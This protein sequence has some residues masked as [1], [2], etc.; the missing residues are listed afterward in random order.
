MNGLLRVIILMVIS[1]LS[2]VVFSIA[3]EGQKSLERTADPI[4]VSGRYLGNLFGVSLENMGLFA[5]A[6]GRFLPIPYQVDEHDAK[7]NLIFSNGK[8][9]GRDNDPAFDIND[10]LVFMV[11]DCGDRVSP[12]NFSEEV[13]KAVELT[14]TDPVNGQKG[15]VYAVAYKDSPKRSPVD[16]VR[17][18]NS[19]NVIYARNY[20]MGFSKSAPIAIGHLA[21]TK[22][23]GGRGDNQADRLKI[24][25]S[26]KVMGLLI[27][28]D[29]EGFSS[30][31]VAWID[32]PV[33]V[34][35]RTKNRQTLFWKIPTPSAYLDNI[36]YANV[37]EFP[38]R[39]DLPFDVKTFLSNP[40]FRVSTD[41]L[42]SVSGR[43]YMNEKNP[44]PVSIDGKMSDAEKKMDKSPYSWM[45]IAQPG[46]GSWMNRLLYDKKSTPAVPKLY[47][48]DDASS[49]DPP[50][51]DPGQ[52]GEVGYTLENLIEVSKGV[53]RLTSVM[54]NIPKF[55]QSKIQDYLNILD[56]PV[57][58]EA[59][60][61]R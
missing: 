43:I 20:T 28:K 13:E 2:I 7:G 57:R 31:V 30:E 55:D 11:S 35:R 16:Y 6:G 19:T 21:M 29:E 46:E 34:V 17:Y 12:E 44:N 24:R 27:E 22:A 1:L 59:I 53:L 40:K 37:F 32:G 60:Q 47:Y 23:G 15:W 42:C 9:A 61:V 45:I 8:K 4:V 49:L 38:T 41:T 52:C 10:E 14:V 48:M 5:S 36:Y 51:E 56:R 50:E 3:S 58:V 26:A 25:F 54:Y 18:D 33:R 39:V